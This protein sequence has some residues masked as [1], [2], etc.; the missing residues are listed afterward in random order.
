MPRVRRE[1]TLPDP[2]KAKYP[3]STNIQPSPTFSPITHQEDLGPAHS[4]SGHTD[5]Q[6]RIASTQFPDQGKKRLIFIVSFIILTLAALTSK[7]WP[8]LSLLSHHLNYPFPSSKFSLSTTT[9]THTTTIK[10]STYS[11][12][13]E[14]AELAVQRAAILT[15]KVFNEKAKGTISKDD[16]SP[17]T[18]GDFGA[19]ALIIQAIKKNFPDDGVV[20]EEEASTLREDTKL[21]DTIWSLVKD[22][23]LTNETAEKVLGGPIES[24]DAMLEAIDAGNSKGGNKGR[25]WA[26]DPIDGTKG[27]LRGGQYAVCLALMVDGD[28]KVG[29]LGCPNLPVDDAAPLTADS[30]VDQTDSE[31]KGVLFSAIL[32]QGA[33]SRPLTDGAVASSKPI[34]MKPVTDL[35][36]TIFCESVEAGHSSHGDQAAIAAKLGITK[37]SVRMDSQAKYGSVARGA[38]DIYLRLPTCATYQEKIWDHAAGDL[39]VREAGG[40]VTDTLGRRL[41]FGQGRTLAENKGVVAAPAAVHGSVLDVVKEVLSKK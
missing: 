25:I 39:I 6:R 41:D 36:E 29:V 22:V 7:F 10:M 27:F 37:P 26:L 17:V 38:G 32:G 11:K 31:G 21:R 30:G 40:Q 4:Q 34:S 2:D 20:G 1:G 14:V 9:T 33:I 24:V 35:K 5:Y 15:K 3:P 23:K 12:E 16:S 19:Q 18:I 13:L 8:R 28:V